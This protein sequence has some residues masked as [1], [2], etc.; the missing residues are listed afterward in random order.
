[1][2]ARARL[3][4]AG[5]RSVAGLLHVR[6]GAGPDTPWATL[7]LEANI[8]HAGRDRPCFGLCCSGAGIGELLGTFAMTLAFRS[9][10]LPAIWVDLH[11]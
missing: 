8:T 4:C 1:M 10:L 2:R 9:E 11:I 7:H 5:L 3:T 6:R